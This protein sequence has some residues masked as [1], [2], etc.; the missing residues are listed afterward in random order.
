MDDSREFKLKL[1]DTRP[2]L[3][4]GSIKP[5]N[6]TPATKNSSMLVVLFAIVVIGAMLVWIFYHLQNQIQTIN[7]E[8]TA[9]ISGLSRE[10]NDKLSVLSRQFSDQKKQNHDLFTNIKIQLKELNTAIS[11]IQANASTKKELEVAINQIQQSVNPLKKTVE[12]LNEQ[13]NDIVKQTK[14]ITTGLNKIQTGVLNNTHEISTLDAIQVDR[15][16]FEAALKKERDFHQGNIAHTTET[17]F[18]E[19]AT[20]QKRIKKIDVQLGNT[21]PDDHS[22]N[23]PDTKKQ[24]KTKTPSES[25]STPKSGE[26]LEHE[27]N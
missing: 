10:F 16:E 26:I 1:D 18:S 2:D 17:L 12:S 9:G 22:S 14:K 6:N 24:L 11:S 15:T 23:A 13:L 7:K 5:K 8:G 3:D 21:D 20:I 25:L 19:I 4:F 27:I